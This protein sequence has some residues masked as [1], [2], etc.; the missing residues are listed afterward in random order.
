MHD[1]KKAKL[2]YTMQDES[3][4]SSMVRY[5]IEASV[6]TKNIKKMVPQQLLSNPDN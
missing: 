5:Q 1:F 3:L 4:P 2:D 6:A